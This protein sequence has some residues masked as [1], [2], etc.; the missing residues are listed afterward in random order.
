MYGGGTF[1]DGEES[2]QW[3]LGTTM[4]MGVLHATDVHGGVH[5]GRGTGIFLRYLFDR[6]HH[7]DVPRRSAVT[8]LWWMHCRR[9]LLLLPGVEVMR[10]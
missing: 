9:Y 3:R 4:G 6:R 10:R 1:L 2:S 5:S 8:S 7:P